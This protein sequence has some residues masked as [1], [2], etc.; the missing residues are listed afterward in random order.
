MFIGFVSAVIALG[1]TFSLLIAGPMVGPVGLGLLLGLVGW[2]VA[3]LYL[4]LGFTIAT[5]AGWI[6]GRMRLEGWLQDWLRELNAG[7]P[8]NVPRESLM[9][10]V[11][12]E[13]AWW[14]VP[15][16]V[17]MG[18]PTYTNAAGVISVVEA[19][20]NKGA[21][22]GTTLAFML[23]VSALSLPEMSI[24]RQAL[25]LRLIAVFVGVMAVGILATDALF[26]AIL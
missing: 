22:P 5:V 20:L 8:G 17:V 11:M 9:T 16:A 21:A 15:A 13:D 24:L 2:Q 7:Q 4:V 10:R 25:T 18:T 26:N 3:A 19:L 14:S 6:L 23:S 1:V 12:G